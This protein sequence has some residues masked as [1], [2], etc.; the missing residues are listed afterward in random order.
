M[1]LT[2]VLGF[3]PAPEDGRPGKDSVNVVLSTY[4]VTAKYREGNGVQT[5]SVYV[6]VY[7]GNERIGTAKFK[8][9]AGTFA[10]GSISQATSGEYTRTVLLNISD[11]K[12]G[13]VTVNLDIEYNGV[14]YNK[15]VSV[16][17]LRDGK[18]GNDGQDTYILD[19][20]NEMD[21]MPCNDKLQTSSPSNEVFTTLT[22]YKGTTAIDMGTP[23]ITNSVNIGVTLVSETDFSKKYK[24]TVYD[25]AAITEN[26]TFKVKVG[27][28]ER[29]AVFTVNKIKPGADGQP[30]TIYRVQP[31]VTS[32]KIAADGTATPT[33]VTCKRTKQTGNGTPVETTEGYL[34]VRLSGS[35]DDMSYYTFF[36]NTGVP[37]AGKTSIEFILYKSMTDKTVLDRETVPVVSDG[38]P[39]DPGKDGTDGTDGE[40]GNG[41]ISQTNYYIATAMRGGVTPHNPATGWV[42]DIFQPPAEETPYAWKFTRTVYTKTGTQ[43]SPCEMIATFQAG[44]NPNLLEDTAFRDEEHMSAWYDINEIAP[45]SG[46]TIDSDYSTGILTGDQGL[47]GHNAFRGG[48]MHTL[49]K[50][51]YKE[52]LQ[53]EITEKIQPGTW[54]TLSFWA[55]AGYDSFMYTD[56]SGN[57]YPFKKWDVYL[58]TGQTYKMQVEGLISSAAA[59]AR[60]ALHVYVCKSDWSW[61]KVIEIKSTSMTTAEISFS[62]VPSSGD[63]NVGAYAYPSGSTNSVTV[64]RLRLYN[65][66]KIGVVYVYPGLIDTAESGYVDGVE[67]TLPSDG[68]IYIPPQAYKRHTLTFKTKRYIDT[69]TRQNILF[70]LM[71]AVADGKVYYMDICMPKLET[72]MIATAYIPN[73]AD[74]KGDR[75]PALRGPQMWNDCSESFYFQQGAD[76]EEWKDVVIYE[77]NYY[78]C[79]KSHSKTAANYP[80]SENS[81]KYGYWRLGDKIELIATRILLAQ[82]ALIKNLGVEAVEMKDA[83]GNILF[84]VRDGELICETGTFNNIMSKSGKFKIDKE[85]RLKAVEADI[86][87]DLNATNLNMRICDTDLNGAMITN[88]DSY[89]LPELPLGR[90]RVLWFFL[91]AKTRVPSPAVITPLSNK[92][93]LYINSSG[94]FSYK[95]AEISGCG[96]L[97]GIGG[98]TETTW[99]VYQ[100]N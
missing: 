51:R 85:G 34:C 58:E 77:G 62:D 42:A 78:S 80:G 92:V 76:G 27:D 29:S 69:T 57:G 56:I 44:A 79:V 30:A 94:V 45:Q 22:L 87:G 53:Q 35:T 86:E 46:V 12:S 36:N 4:A 47:Q 24:I 23:T 91:P 9:T 49:S 28:I 33:H 63:Y 1:R 41:I 20:D 19:L 100:F 16:S 71:P 55:H 11:G 18:D 52:I 64:H 88:V 75:G 90:T 43:D 54:Y 31:S 82:Y 48:T 74:M 66:K 96:I 65:T 70:R 40:D 32:A 39:G 68:A 37:V 26:V 60:T 98:E 84:K 50:I 97:V 81:D 72:G 8:V 38:K 10:L 7:E 73:T 21:A 2:K 6:M 83:D 93:K 15:T 13:T 61:S 5:F 89:K 95:E 67:T 14:T 59:A 25:A 3:I 17:V 99:N